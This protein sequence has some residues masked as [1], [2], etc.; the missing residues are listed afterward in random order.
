MLTSLFSE[1]LLLDAVILAEAGVLG[2]LWTA[3][4]SALVLIG[5]AYLLPGVHI[6]GFGSALVLAVITGGLVGLIGYFVDGLG[7]VGALVVTT[8]ALIIGDK[9]MDSVKLD[10]WYWA[11]AVAVIVSLL[12]GVPTFLGA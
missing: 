7:W 3:L 2:Y 11:L 10:A 1:P 8:L 9:L 5:C 6:S 12:S 4:I